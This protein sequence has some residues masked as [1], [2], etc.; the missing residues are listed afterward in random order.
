M[1]EQVMPA[2]KG[3]DA[4]QLRAASC[5]S[6]TVADRLVGVRNIVGNA[7]ENAAWQGPNATQFRDEWADRGSQGVMAAAEIVRRLADRL[8][9]EANRR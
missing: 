2:I 7:L 8:R 5:S 3:A 1:K 9:L 4:E 6:L